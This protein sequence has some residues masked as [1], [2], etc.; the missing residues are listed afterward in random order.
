MDTEKK[1]PGQPSFFQHLLPVFRCSHAF[2]I[3]PLGLFM[4]SQ[5]GKIFSIF[6]LVIL[7]KAVHK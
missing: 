2:V 5:E 7:V 1:Q 6:Y 3:I 4:G